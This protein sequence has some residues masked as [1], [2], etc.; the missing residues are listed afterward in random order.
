VNSSFRRNLNQIGDE[1]QM[2]N[3]VISRQSAVGSHQSLVDSRQ[4]ID[5]IE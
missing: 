1:M 4:Q 2:K 5:L 3:V